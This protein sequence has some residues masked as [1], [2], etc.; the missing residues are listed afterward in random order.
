VR[1]RRLRP[2]WLR[3]PA[4]V[5]GCLTVTCTAASAAN[6]RIAG[7]DTGAY[8]D[9]RVTV[10]AP[11]GS[12]QP[13]LRENGVPVTDLQALDLG[14]AKSIVLAVDRSESMR[15]QSLSRAIGAALAF[16]GTKTAGDR[17]EVMSF[18]KDA[19][20]DTGFSTSAASIDA[21]LG[22]I[23]TDSH[24]GTAL[25]DA[26]QLASRQLQG[27]SG[28][29]HVIIVLTDGRDVSSSATLATAA[30]AAEQAKASV[31]TIGIDGPDFTPAPL[32]ALAQHTG[33]SFHEASST[34]RLL[35]IYRSISQVLSHTWELR[36]PTGGRPGES[37]SLVASVTG[38]GSTRADVVRLP[39]SAPASAST[40]VLSRSTWLAP[41]MP[42]AV[43]G[44]V[45]ILVL[46][47]AG[48]ATGAQRGNWVR[49]RLEPHLAPVRRNVRAR[50][51][52]RRA[53][54]HRVVSIT[55]R[56]LA[57]V[58]QFRAL[59]R[60]L[61]RADLP[62][63]AGELVYVCV[64][65]GV[66]AGVLTAIASR[67]ATLTLLF[68]ALGGWV[69]I[70]FVK[71]KASR[72]L[73]AFDNQLPDLLITISASLK[74]G[75]S[76]RQ[77][78]QSV[79]DEGAQPTAGE[80]SRVLSET[81]LGRPMELA[82]RDMAQRVGS[83]NLTFVITAV[84]IQRQVGGS[85]AG[86]FDMVAETVRQRQQFSRKVRGL[87]AMG[88]A[89]AYVLLALP[90]FIALAVTALNPTYMAPLYDTPIG[91]LLIGIALTMMAFG[92]VV[93]RRL[94]AFAG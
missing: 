9:V 51:R 93:L 44:A 72:R 60:L 46:L 1:R 13:S 43:S 3:L 85:L 82:L 64:G 50:G 67:S 41:W 66:L 17:I 47:A 57:D 92:T 39:G 78:I 83:K 6:V 16:V 24:A 61:E 62:L 37:L 69:P 54:V 53:L 65:S 38:A 25:W 49:Q 86:L 34:A 56:T 48:I 45:G 5:F 55:E 81:Q 79:V 94:V 88:R 73:R 58:K 19:R 68:T 91:H 22:A 74:A 84:T 12:A 29:A 75:H 87:T 14:G 90:F 31:Y 42:L 71:F 89:S 23:R 52:R 35:G 30:A 36:Y 32:Q 7:V 59:Q 27:Q 28:R 76:F 15:G 10:V 11:A 8:P 80:F 20:A 70:L 77:A 18:G 2:S 26:I 40:G 21:A 63:R 4:L 33:G